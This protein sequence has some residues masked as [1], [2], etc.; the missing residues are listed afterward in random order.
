MISTRGALALQ[1]CTELAKALLE[2]LNKR[3]KHLESDEK[4][5][6]AAAFHPIFRNLGWLR[7]EKHDNLP[8]LPPLTPTPVVPVLLQRQR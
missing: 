2:G 4:C 8:S 7:E 1:H 5:V 6:L 3:F